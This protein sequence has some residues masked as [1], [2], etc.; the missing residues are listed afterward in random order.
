MSAVGAPSTSRSTVWDETFTKLKAQW[1]L[2]L[3][4][5]AGLRSMILDL[6]PVPTSLW[7]GGVI[8]L[9]FLSLRRM[10]RFQRVLR[11]AIPAGD[12]IT[13]EVAKAAT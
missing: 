12:A 2:W 1:A 10:Y 13:A 3:K 11:R 6:P 9:L 7:L 8:T 5:L 4:N